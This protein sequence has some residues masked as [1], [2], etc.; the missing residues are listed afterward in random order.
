MKIPIRNIYYLL[1]YA[2]DAL[3]QGDT[4]PV[5]V[6]EAATTADLLAH[7]L[8]RGVTR[9]LKRGTM[10]DY[11]VI[12]GPVAGVRGKLLLSETLPERW[13]RSG[14]TVCGFDELSG[15]VLPNQIIKAT[16]ARLAEVSEI[17]RTI[18]GQLATIH[19]RLSDVSDIRLTAATF[20][21]V[22]LHRHIASYKFLLSVCRLVHSELM[23]DARGAHIVFRDFVQ[24]EDRMAAL[25]Q[26]FLF[27]F[28]RREQ[29]A[30]AVGAPQIRWAT[31]THTV[32]DDMFLP[33]MQTDAVLIGAERRIVLDAKYYR[34]SFRSRFG[35]DKVRSDHLYQI[36]SYVQNLAATPGAAVEGLLLYP[37]V[38]QDFALRYVILGFPV[39]VCSVDLNQPW[40]QIRQRLLDLTELKTA[41]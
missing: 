40:K 37:T 7:L 6:E 10:Q 14:R 25:F 34:E 27:N 36:M 32:T 33:L 1:S 30:F 13:R 21:R 17:A 26:R 12:N 35:N 2:W 5:G 39:C 41:A 3:P 18:R 9:L 38:D 29:P 22:Q 23:P 8:V 16:L 31:R 11:R 24:D 28:Y 20:S 15:D 4:V 19:R